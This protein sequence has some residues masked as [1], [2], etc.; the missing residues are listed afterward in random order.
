MSVN[1]FIEQHVLPFTEQTEA[2]YL[3]E[4]GEGIYEI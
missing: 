2:R 1:D 3:A 4:S